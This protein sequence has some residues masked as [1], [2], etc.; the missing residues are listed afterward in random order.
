[1]NRHIGSSYASLLLPS[2]HPVT[3]WPRIKVFL[4]VRIMTFVIGFDQQPAN[5]YGLLN[6]DSKTL[7]NILQLNLSINSTAIAV[8]RAKLI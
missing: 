1:M 8:L 5:L 6:I 2:L 4:E 3:V 7:G